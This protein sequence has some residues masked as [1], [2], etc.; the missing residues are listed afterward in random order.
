MF[1]LTACSYN[2]LLLQYHNNKSYCPDC[3]GQ[4]EVYELLVANEDDS[5][6]GVLNLLRRERVW[7]NYRGYSMVFD[8]PPFTG[9]DQD[10]QLYTS[11]FRSIRPMT[12]L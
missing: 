10:C 1:D 6:E 4:E 7:I 8:S 2:H 12:A 11:L 3:V 9:S 5:I